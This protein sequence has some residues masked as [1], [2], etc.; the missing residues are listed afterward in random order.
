[1]RLPFNQTMQCFTNKAHRYQCKIVVQKRL[2]VNSIGLA[3]NRGLGFA[4]CQLD[5]RI[6]IHNGDMFGGAVIVN[7]GIQ[8]FRAGAQRQ[9]GA[10]VNQLWFNIGCQKLVVNINLNG[11]GQ[12]GAARQG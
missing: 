1:M 2:G 10:A 12:R 9:I 7:A 5:F 8:R 11:A 6:A 4:N 3:I